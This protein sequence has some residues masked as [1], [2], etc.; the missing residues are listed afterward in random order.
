M[1]VVVFLIGLVVIGI[2]VFKGFKFKKKVKGKD[3]YVPVEEP[4]IDDMQWQFLRLLNAYRKEIGISELIPE[5]LCGLFAVGRIKE[6][7]KRL[8]E[9][10]NHEGYHAYRLKLEENGLPY[11]AEIIARYFNSIPG[12]F[13]NYIESPGHLKDIE[14]PRYKYVGLGVIVHNYK[15]YS[16]IIFAS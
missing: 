3:K 5:V 13:R 14:N 7:S 4:K 12:M 10:F 6:L 16:C 11:N 15:F 1:D 8:P 9:N 2:L